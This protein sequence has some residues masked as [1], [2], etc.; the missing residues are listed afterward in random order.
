MSNDKSSNYIQKTPL[1]R[2]GQFHKMHTTQKVSG[3]VSSFLAA[4]EDWSDIVYEHSKM[5]LMVQKQKSSHVLF[6]YFFAK[7][8]QK[9]PPKGV[10]HDC[11]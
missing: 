10:L 1:Q 9:D 6:P 11:S 8:V 2:V 3:D 7:L 4:K 5:I